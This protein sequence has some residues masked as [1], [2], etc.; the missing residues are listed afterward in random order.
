MATQTFTYSGD[1]VLTGN[2]DATMTL[3]TFT[4]DFKALTEVDF[5]YAASNT[6]D[7]PPSLIVDDVKYVVYLKGGKKGHYSS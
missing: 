4:S 1:S 6:V 2:L 3:G 7:A 5:T